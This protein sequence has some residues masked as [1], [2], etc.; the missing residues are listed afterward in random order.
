M[1]QLT[2]Q[3]AIVTGAAVG[4]GQA[5]AL[6]YG[7]EG[8]KVVVNYSKSRREAAETAEQIKSAGGEALL[9]KADVSQDDQVREMVN[10]TLAHFGRVDI[11]VN[12]AGL[13]TFVPFEDLEDL[14][15][16]I[17]DDTYDINVKGTF[18]CSRAVVV[19][20]RQQGKGCIINIASVGGLRPR[21]NSI[22]YGTSKAAVIHLTKCLAR[23]MGPEIRV[24]A[25]APGLIKGTRIQNSRPNIAEHLASFAK[26]VPLRRA[27]DVEDVTEVA[28]FLAAGGRFMTGAVLVVDGGRQL[29]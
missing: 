13:G 19:P 2:G 14:T 12:N 15:T 10:Q 8:A 3:V 1:A 23:I 25:I 6:A 9:I 18:L 24:N 26:S 4:I 28:T 27:G 11:L 16:Q 29:V 17:W 21:A 20:M 7:R 5:I 22:A